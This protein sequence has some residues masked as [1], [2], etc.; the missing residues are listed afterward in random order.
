MNAPSIVIF[1]DGRARWGP[2]GDLRAPFE[3]RD[4][5]ARPIDRIAAAFGGRGGDRRVLLV[6]GAVAAVVARRWPGAAVNPPPDACDADEPC[7]FING[8]WP[9]VQDRQAVQ[10]LQQDQSL[11]DAAGDPIAMCATWK[12]WLDRGGRLGTHPIG[13]V[14]AVERTMPSRPWHVLDE[15]ERTLSHDLANAALAPWTGD[16]KGVWIDG[17][18]PVLAAPS[19][20][21][22]PGVVFDTAR[23]PVVLDEQVTIGGNAVVEGPCYVGHGSRIGPLTQ[24]R[25]NTVIGRHCKVGGEVSFC[26]IDDYSNKSHAGFLGHSILGQFVNLGADTNVS[27][28]KNTYGRVRARLEHDAEPED[29]GTIFLGPLIGDFVRT[30]IGTRLTTG[31]VIGTG[32]MIAVSG[33]APPFVD[34]LSFCTDAGVRPH[35]MDALI[36]TARTMKGRRQQELWAQEEALLRG[37]AGDV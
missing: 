35:D 33:F 32:S 4:G 26:V 9:G 29:T 24:V 1:D 6:D 18:H 3:R 20:R 10:L 11:V 27:N 37:L 28:L 22:S 31:S 25:A 36:A 5:A 2:L 23:G 7:L 8:R 34:R 14:I 12:Q 19:V 30:A 17:A 16:A 21:V 15:L 13:R